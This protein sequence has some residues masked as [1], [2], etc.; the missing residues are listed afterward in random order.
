MLSVF[1]FP[2]TIIIPLGRL[3]HENIRAWHRDWMTAPQCVFEQYPRSTSFSP[4]Y[5]DSVVRFRLGVDQVWT[6]PMDQRDWELVCKRT[7]TNSEHH[8]W[9]K[10]NKWNHQEEIASEKATNV[11]FVF[12]SLGF[13]FVPPYPYIINTYFY[14]FISQSKTNHGTLSMRY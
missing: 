11:G 5:T 6:S 10:R 1:I 7:A 8:R 9:E 4:H 13:F 14:I 2:K 3:T 12:I